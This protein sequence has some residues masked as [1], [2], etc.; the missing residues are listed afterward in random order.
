MNVSPD[1]YHTKA[2]TELDEKEQLI[3]SQL[4]GDT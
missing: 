3:P 2:N 1:I 4:A